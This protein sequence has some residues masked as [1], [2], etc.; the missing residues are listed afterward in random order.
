MKP[1]NRHYPNGK[2]DYRKALV[3][4]VDGAVY[5]AHRARKHLTHRMIAEQS[6]MTGPGL[7]NVL[8]K[9]KNLS[10]KQLEKV[11]AVMG[12]RLTYEVDPNAGITQQEEE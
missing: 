6:G 1:T 3:D 5:D 10:L 12:H 11:L 8:N 7:S 2:F 4:V 9:R